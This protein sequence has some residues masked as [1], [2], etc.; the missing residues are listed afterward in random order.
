MKQIFLL[1]GLFFLSML[2]Y[3]DRVAISAAKQPIATDLGLSD[4]QMGIVFGA[5]SLGYAL[6]QVPAGALMDRFGPRVGLFSVVSL[7]SALTGLTGLIHGY[8]AMLATRF[9]FGMSEAGAFPGAA[10]AIY[11]WLPA[12]ARG[13]AN[14]IL[15]SGS[16]IGAA[17]A[18]PLITWMIAATNWRI[19]F[20]IL[21]ASGLVWAGLWYAFFRDHPSD[22]DRAPDGPAAG[23]A[24]AAK[25]RFS[26]Q[27][28]RSWRLVLAMAQY[29]ASNFTF[30]LCLSW[31]YVYLA[32]T[33]SLTPAEASGYAAIPLLFGAACQWITGWMVD[34]LYQSRYRSWS[35]RLPAMI[36]F[37]MS[38][39]G[40]LLLVWADTPFYATACFTLATFGADMTVSPSWS[41][42]ADIGGPHAGSVSASMNMIGN[43]GSFVSASIFPVLLRVTGSGAAYFLV[44]AALN[45]LAIAC[46]YGMRSTE[47]TSI[48]GPLA[49]REQA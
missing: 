39:L 6:M 45:A 26:W 24:H 15:F 38:A 14:G 7:W 29:F 46:W 33:Y 10:R 3:V 40:M 44:A 41:F 37:L 25:V 42:C 11:N 27:V 35:R 47:G 30:F 19:S 43:L 5:F 13:I 12:S 32:Q 2:T 36:G 21:A 9:S 34:A 4:D 23:Q 22:Q 48:A 16:R 28:F 20:F 8:M 17:F 49:T 31:M 18:F 1:V